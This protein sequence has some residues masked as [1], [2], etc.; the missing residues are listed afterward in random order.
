MII[1]GDPG[2][3]LSVSG[4]VAEDVPG[5]VRRIVDMVQAVPGWRHKWKMVTQLALVSTAEFR[6]DGQLKYQINHKILLFAL[7]CLPLFLLKMTKYHGDI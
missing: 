6:Q 4:A 5:M 3:N 1:S 2:L 7:R